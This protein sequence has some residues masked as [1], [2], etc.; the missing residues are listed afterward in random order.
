M[1]LLWQFLDRGHSMVVGDDWRARLLR[2][3]G[4]RLAMRHHRVTIPK[5]CRIHPAAA[6]HPRKASIRF[7]EECTV[8]MGAIVQGAVS[9]GDR[10]SIQSG[11]IL[12]GYGEG[13]HPAGPVLIGNDVRIAPLVQ[14]IAGNHDISDPEA[15]IGQ[16]LGDPIRIGDRVWVGGRAI[17][18]AGVCVG[19]NAIIAAG[20]VV[21]K[22]VPPYAIV[23]GIPAKVIRM[24]KQTIS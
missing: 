7:G 15:P 18:T 3:F 2:C 24:R 19:H 12:V 8:S 17:V 11:S 23:A 10:C 14:M 13:E 6:I 1:S 22:D 9:L 4:R 16:V 5:S 20:A 21:T